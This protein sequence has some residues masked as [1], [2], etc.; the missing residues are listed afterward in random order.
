MK[1]AALVARLTLAA[2]AV[3]AVACKK[4]AEPAK[5]ASSEHSGGDTS[6]SAG[7]A[8]TSA[9]SQRKAQLP[10]MPRKLPNGDLA[11][12]ESDKPG[13]PWA[14]GRH[15][16]R[17]QM[18]AMRDERRKQALD[19]FDAD[20]NGELDDTEREAMHEARTAD[21]VARMD[22]NADGKLTKEEVEASMSSRRRPPP[23][24]DQ[25]DTNHDGFVT[26]EEL[27]AARPARGFRGRGDD[28]GAPPV[29][30]DPQPDQP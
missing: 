2:F 20:K 21:M 9:D 16:D 1:A 7:G 28:S 13:R 17:E 15:P 23:D 24:F 25:I 10:A 11:P 19:T 12:G 3:G 14:D 22:S 8:E 27:S 26:V 4:E 30:P 6:S 29:R 5:A 18:K